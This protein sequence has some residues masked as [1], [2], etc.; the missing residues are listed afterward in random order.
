MVLMMLLWP[1]AVADEDYHFALNLKAGP[2]VT[3]T[4]KPFIGDSD[5]APNGC[6]AG[7]A[8]CSCIYTDDGFMMRGWGTQGT[9][10][11]LEF[12]CTGITFSIPGQLTDTCDCTFRAMIAKWGRSRSI[13]IQCDPKR[14]FQ[15]KDNG[16]SGT[17]N[18]LFNRFD[19]PNGG[20]SINAVDWTF[21]LL[22]EGSGKPAQPPQIL[23]GWHAVASGAGLA[24]KQSVTWS[25]TSTKANAK[26]VSNSLTM[27]AK[28]SY[29]EKAGVSVPEVGSAESSMGVELSTSLTTGWRNTVTSTMS[30]TNGGSEE[31]TCSPVSCPG[32]TTFQWQT[33]V[34]SGKS[35][36]ALFNSCFFVCMPNQN[37]RP[38]C[39]YGACCTNSAADQCSR[40]SME[41][42]DKSDPECPLS[43]PNVKIG[44]SSKSEAFL[45]P[46][47]GR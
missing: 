40:C 29:S 34:N 36:G 38:K 21:N 5:N 47:Q 6:G 9:M 19:N 20:G 11:G 12:Q 4:G 35:W 7:Y 39:P 22:A 24:I 8:K 14:C 2:G 37:E 42:C 31:T 1:L 28:Y 16:G 17:V 27:G 46:I 41:W 45:Q 3:I 18:D 13:E 43:D 44:C 26:E 10:T 23:G 32:G 33:S 25:S 15:F 30:N